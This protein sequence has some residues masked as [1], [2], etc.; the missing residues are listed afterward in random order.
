MVPRTR[1]GLE[2]RESGG[3]GVSSS[4]MIIHPWD[5]KTRPSALEDM[6]YQ[7][8]FYISR[9]GELRRGGTPRVLPGIA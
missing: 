4:D 3:H 9:L 8:G 6:D 7:A 2:T 1:A 5:S